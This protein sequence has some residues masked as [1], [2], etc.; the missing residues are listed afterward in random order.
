MST[1]ASRWIDNRIEDALT[2]AFR[3][4]DRYQRDGYCTPD[5]VRE[6]LRLGWDESVLDAWDEYAAEGAW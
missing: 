4:I 2:D 1:P 5:D 6:A 3:K